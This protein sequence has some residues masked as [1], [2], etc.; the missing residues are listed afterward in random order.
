MKKNKNKMV[1]ILGPT[2]TGK[3]GLAVKLARKYHGEVIS[4]DSRQVY[5]GLDIGTGKITK[6]EMQGIHHWL[7]DIVNPKDSFSVAQFQEQVR[8][9]IQTILKR[10]KLP[11]I[12]GGT[13]FYID[14]VVN[15]T[16]LPEV[17]PNKKLRAKLEKKS[18]EELALMLK[19]LD[20]NRY[21]NIDINNKVRL[22]RAIE[23]ATAIG[24]VPK[25]INNE[26]EYNFLK[27]GLVLSNE[28]LRSKINKRLKL[29]IK[30]GMIEEAERLHKKGLSYERMRELGLEYRYLADFLEK[31][32]S[33]IEMISKLETEIWRYAK[34]QMTWFK[35]DKRIKWFNPKEIRKIQK[36]I[37]SFLD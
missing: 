31:K 28:D 27:I 6:D 26:S 21:N 29:R 20:E 8:A 19:Q 14:S 32:I 22:V 11:I 24:K 17:P 36:E 30:Q 35:K 23:I 12:C 15:N 3:S 7:L 18:A 10:S 16:V 33:K 5:K 9:K 25:N 4:A 34:R 37:N 2:A 1:V 13:G